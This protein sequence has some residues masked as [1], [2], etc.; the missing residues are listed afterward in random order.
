M[1]S[2]LLNFSLLAVI[3]FLCT[4]CPYESNVPVDV[5]KNPINE[6]IL[7]RWKESTEK[8]VDFVEI[9]KL[10]DKQYNI[11]NY[12]HNEEKLEFKTETYLAHLSQVDGIDFLNISSTKK[13]STFMIYKMILVDDKKT[14]TLFPL[15]EHIREKFTTSKELQDFISKYKDLS[16]FYGEETVYVR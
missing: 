11:T 6:T 12:T 10:N 8:G 13:T 5:A 16:F 1:K 3:L 7:G 2:K 15:S 14:M 9:T 4:A